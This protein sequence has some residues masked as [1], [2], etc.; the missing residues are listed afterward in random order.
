MNGY[1]PWQAVYAHSDNLDTLQPVVACPYC[2]TPHYAMP[3]TLKADYPDGLIK[4]ALCPG[5]FHHDHATGQVSPH[6]QGSCRPWVEPEITEVK[7][8]P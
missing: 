4:C 8:N 7:F 5:T 6:D 3:R 1:Y 2:K